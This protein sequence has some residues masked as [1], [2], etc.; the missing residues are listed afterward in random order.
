MTLRERVVADHE[1]GLALA[2]IVRRNRVGARTV[3]RWVRGVSRPVR[4]GIL[5]AGA[6]VRVSLG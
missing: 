6:A 3:V 4:I 5:R 1:A 2:E